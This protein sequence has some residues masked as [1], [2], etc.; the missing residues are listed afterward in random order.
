MP[1]L[2]ASSCRPLYANQAQPSPSPTLPW[3]A[4][5]LLVATLLLYMS[6]KIISSYRGNKIQNFL[7]KLMVTLSSSAVLYY[8][9]VMCIVNIET[10]PCLV[11]R[12]KMIL[13]NC[14]E[15]YIIWHTI[16]V[17]GSPNSSSGPTPKNQSAYISG[18]WIYTVKRWE[19]T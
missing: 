1:R 5:M 9:S 16:L 19:K 17:V 14:E 2:W 7:W 3:D 18:H 6:T 13:S 15:A 12:Y 8:Y 10:T 11:S 4:V